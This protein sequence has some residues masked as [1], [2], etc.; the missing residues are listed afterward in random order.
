MTA[1]GMEFTILGYKINFRRKQ[2]KEPVDSFVNVR[3][4]GSLAPKRPMTLAAVYRCVNVISESV[5]QLPLETYR[6]DNDGYKKLYV[7]HPAFDLLREYPSPDMTRFIFL[8]TLV[9]SMLLEGNG[10][11]YIDRDNFGNALSIQYIPSGMVNITYI[12]TN[13]GPR[14]RYQVTGFRHLV[15][16]IDMIHLMNFSYDGVKGVST[17]THARNTIGIAGA[18]EDFAKDFF[19]K[20][21]NVRG[22]LSYDTKLR[23]GQRE[24]IKKAWAEMINDGGIGVLE[25]NSRYQ[26]ISISPSDAQM[27][28][29]RQYD[30]I[31]ICRFFGVSPVKAFDLSKSSYSTVEATQLSF[32]TDTLAPIL[33]NI[34]LEFK[35]KVFRPSERSGIELKFNTDNLLRADKAAQANWIKTKIEAGLSTINEARRDLDLPRVDNGDRTL[36]NNAMVPLE[37]VVS[38]R[39]E[40]QRTVS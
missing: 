29:T 18:A 26:S 4:Y 3:R 25:A 6:K 20:G 36:V 33:E 12:N 13:S 24:D 7:S 14:M 23:E 17:L 2:E 38:K 27:L 16:P 39:F 30:V 15:E 19:S 1:A 5:A 21:G 8:K 37:Y 34:E 28:E 35:R 32:L 22:I 9:S 10:Y 11:A 31:D 40:P